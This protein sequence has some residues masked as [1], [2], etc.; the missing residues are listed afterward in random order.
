MAA[1]Y[2]PIASI[3][4]GA[5]ATTVTFTSIP[6]TYTDLVFVINAKNDTTTNSEIRFN[7]DSGS[8]YSATALY[9]N[10]SS[11]ASTR[12]TSTAQASIDWNAYI[13]TGDFAY[14]NVINIMN[15]SNTTTYKTFLA[16]ANSAA[17]GV[18]LIAGLWRS[19]A[20]INSLTILTTTGTRNFASG[21]T[22]NLYGI[23]GANA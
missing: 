16:R 3:T 23:L 13:T 19:T 6:S 1:T 18:D 17:N 10:G 12:E 5:N 9:G 8:N 21:S 20:A 22:F 11:A 15:Y 2:T 4:L 14:S 7:S